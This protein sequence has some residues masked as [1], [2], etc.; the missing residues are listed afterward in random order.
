MQVVQRKSGVRP[1]SEICLANGLWLGSV[2]PQLMNLLY[3]EQL[4]I[5]HI[6]HSKCIIQVSSGMHKMKANVIMFENSMPKIY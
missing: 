4:L 3:A 2:P 1:D 5:S 6:C